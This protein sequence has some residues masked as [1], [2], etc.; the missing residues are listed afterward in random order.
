MIVNQVL[1]AYFKAKRQEI[2]NS[3][4]VHPRKISLA[5]IS[6][7]S[8]ICN[9]KVVLDFQYGHSL[10]KNLVLPSLIKSFSQKETLEFR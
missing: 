7:S 4:M 6:S 5:E 3:K 8:R 9:D 10:K 2:H 1:L